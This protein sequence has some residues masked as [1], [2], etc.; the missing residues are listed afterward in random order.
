MMAL[1]D[2]KPEVIKGRYFLKGMLKTSM[3]PTLK[4][5]LTKYA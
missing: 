5:D 1:I 2:R 4:V 3:G